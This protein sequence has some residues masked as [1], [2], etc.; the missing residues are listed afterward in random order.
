LEAVVTALEATMERIPQSARSNYNAILPVG[1]IARIAGLDGPGERYCERVT[2]D[3]VRFD[4]LR[5]GLYR[6]WLVHGGTGGRAAGLER[7]LASALRLR[8]AVD[9]ETLLGEI[10]LGVIAICRAE[11]AVVVYDAGRNEVR[12]KV[13]TE[14]GVASMAP[15]DTEVSLTA[16]AKVRATGHACLFDDACGDDDLGDR[17]SVMRFRPRSLIIAPL[18][19]LGE[20]LGYVYV[21][22]RSVVKS[23]S[24]SDVQLVEGFAAQAALALENAQLVTELRRSCEELERARKDAIR[25]ESLRV[26][27]RMASEVAHD[28][29]NLLTAIIGE[30][31]LLIHDAA[32]P[33]VAQQLSVIERAALDGAEVIRR[34]QDSTRVRDDK[35]FDVVSVAEV[36][37]NVLDMIRWRA[38]AG[39]V[40]VATQIPPDLYVRGVASE[41][42]EVFTNV[43]LNA[44][45]AMPGGGDL[46]VEATLTDGFVAI[47]IMDTG[48]GMTADTLAKVFDPFFTTKGDR[49]NGLGLSIA[50]GIMQRHGGEIKAESV[51]GRGTRMVVSL[52]VSSPAERAAGARGRRDDAAGASVAGENLR[53]LVVDDEPTVARILASMLKRIG[54][55][56]EVSIGGTA[57]LSRIASGQERFDVVITDVNMPDKNG[58]DVARELLSEERGPR[59]IVMSGSLGGREED[60]AKMLGVSV[61]RKPF[62]ISDVNR[63]LF[64][65]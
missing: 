49:G 3:P 62:T 37:D 10:A 65:P 45:D 9:V 57:A 25:G 24:D 40:R 21:E 31:Q 36:L 32:T 28:F 20:H 11:R 43:V 18:Q 27:G 56:P 58:I 59:V 17:P 48:S 29:N 61:L 30:T 14:R 33:A 19:T 1:M 47:A 39:E 53:V 13:A 5:A 12:A 15:S 23:F 41:L 50:Y 26:L 8:S 34:I 22:N 54:A 44:L 55:E 51:V 46:R 7:V 6:N 2:E 63:V 16:V 64:S 60:T 35:T 42:R 38:S 52:P 4:R